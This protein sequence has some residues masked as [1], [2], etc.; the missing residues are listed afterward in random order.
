MSPMSR[1]W[2]ILNQIILFSLQ[3][4]VFEWFGT[5]LH[6]WPSLQLMANVFNRKTVKT[7][8][9]VLDLDCHVLC[10]WQWN[11]QREDLFWRGRI[12]SSPPSAQLHPLWAPSDDCCQAS[13]CLPAMR[14]TDL[15]IDYREPEKIPP[16]P[17]LCCFE[18]YRYFCSRILMQVLQSIYKHSKPL[19]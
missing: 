7:L 19:H 8:S 12:S 2:T 9:L 15:H 4:A 6:Y 13:W 16:A 17:W 14:S 1:C 10:C 5:W 3:W 11:Y 18:A